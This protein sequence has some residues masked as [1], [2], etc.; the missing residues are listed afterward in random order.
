MARFTQRQYRTQ[1][2]AVMAVYVALMLGEWPHVRDTV[3]LP[4]KVTLALLPVA[5]MFV[6]IWL[7]ARRVMHSDELQQRLYLLALGIAAAVVCAASLVGGFL[8]ASHAI[9]LDGDVLIWVF[10][11]LS[12]SFGIAHLWLG[13]R[14]GYGGCE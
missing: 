5:P 1:L 3:S 14:Y 10:P 6:V 7:I 12:G 9:A 2:L 11:L 8:A 13:R 4:V